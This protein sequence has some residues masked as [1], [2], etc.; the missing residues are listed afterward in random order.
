MMKMPD[1][2]MRGGESGMHEEKGMHEGMGMDEMGMDAGR[3]SMMKMMMAVEHLDLTPEQRK[4]IKSLRLQHQKEAIPLFGKIRMAGLEVEELLMADPVDLEKVK[5]RT[6]E[7]Y[8]AM[9][10]LEMAHHQLQ[11]QIKTLLTPEQRQ[12][13]E[14]MMMKPVHGMG[15]GMDQ[16]KEAP[17]GKMKPPKGAPGKP[18]P[19][20][21]DP[22]GH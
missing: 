20:T 5:A 12:H 21:D 1:E 14:E 8:E 16:K 11:Q 9:A 22:H 19:K 18:A 3:M 6:K 17:E 10:D 15:Y 13:L 4:K 7:K 2:G